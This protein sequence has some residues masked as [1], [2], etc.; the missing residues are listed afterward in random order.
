MALRFKGD[1]LVREDGSVFEVPYEALLK[2]CLRENYETVSAKEIIFAAVLETTGEVA[3]GNTYRR[4]SLFNRLEEEIRNFPI[5]QKARELQMEKDKKAREDLK[6][7]QASM[8]FFPSSP[9]HKKKLRDI[10]NRFYRSS[11]NR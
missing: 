3:I 1:N 7:L 5:Y 6:N 10:Q 4:S 9:E 8:A 11:F 2:A